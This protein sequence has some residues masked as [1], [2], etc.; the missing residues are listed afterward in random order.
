MT[1]KEE[2]RTITIFH[3]YEFGK[4]TSYEQLDQIDDDYED[5]IFAVA[6]KRDI[7]GYLK[8]FIVTLKEEI[9]A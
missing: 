9:A 5:R 6:E 2:R 3:E 7:F 1:C 4:A 8:G